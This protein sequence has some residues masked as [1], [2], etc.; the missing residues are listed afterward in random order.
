MHLNTENTRL[1]GVYFGKLDGVVDIRGSFF[2]LFKSSVFE[3]IISGFEIREAYVTESH[4]NVLRGMHYQKKP[5]EHDKVVICL[6]G[7]IL[8]VV[9]G[10]SGA[11]KGVFCSK[12]LS[13]EGYNIVFIPAGYAHGFLSLEDNTKL[14]Y[15]V[16][17][18]HSPQHDSGICWDSFG[19][20]WPID[21]PILSQRDMEHPS[22]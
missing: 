15:L 1:E 14:L 4:K 6:S 7:S 13:R 22:L 20:E 3:K 19:F 16:S 17:T 18:E 2:K 9:L 8:D 11:Y 21:N 5:E 10:I 12:I